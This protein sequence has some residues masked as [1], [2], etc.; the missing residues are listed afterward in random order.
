MDG[1]ER[2]G[3]ST[4]WRRAP[5]AP[6]ASSVYANV[7]S[8]LAVFFA[9]AGGTAYAL[10]GSNTVFTDD[11]IDNQVTQPTSATTPSVSAGSTARTWGP[12]RWEFR[13]G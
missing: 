11:I 3:A 9:L 12:A 10:D 6:Q 13:G 2:A 1:S 5:H 4:D 7:M 8:T